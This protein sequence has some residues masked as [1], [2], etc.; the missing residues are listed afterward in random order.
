MAIQNTDLLIAYRPANQA[1]YKL[2]LADLP[3]GDAIVSDTAP[4]PASYSEGQLWWNSDSTSGSL[5]VLYN[6]P[7][8]GAGGDTGGLKWV[9]ASPTVILDDN[10]DPID[11]TGDYLKT[12]EAAGDQVVLS[13]GTTTFDGV[14][15]AGDGVSVTGGSVVDNGITKTS[16]SPSNT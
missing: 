3:G 4:D 15:E 7:S 1:H 5:F 10:G 14:V 6:D 8:G 9:E 16:G 2:S 13:T 11:I 12:D